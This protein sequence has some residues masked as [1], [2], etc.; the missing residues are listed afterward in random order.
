MPPS[1]RGVIAGHLDCRH[2]RR[3][4]G[5]RDRIVVGVPAFIGMGQNRGN[6]DQ[7]FA[8][9]GSQ[10][11]HLQ[12]TQSDR[13]FAAGRVAWLDAASAQGGAE[14]ALARGGIVLA[15]R[16]SRSVCIVQVAWRAVRHMHQPQAPEQRKRCAGADRLVIRVRDHHGDRDIDR[17]A[18]SQP[19]QQIVKSFPAT[20]ACSKVSAAFWAGDANRRWPPRRCHSAGSLRHRTRRIP[21]AAAVARYSA[22]RSPCVPA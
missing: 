17:L 9:L 2:A 8:Q 4:H 6:P 13:E 19:K 20:S 16:K 14:F 1:G 22:P 7:Y 10:R 3:L 21:P 15:A 18:A 11:D 12:E 5:K